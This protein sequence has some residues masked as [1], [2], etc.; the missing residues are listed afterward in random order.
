MSYSLNHQCH[1]FIRCL[2]L[3]LNR[4]LAECTYNR[5]PTEMGD[6]DSSMHPMGID[7]KKDLL[8]KIHTKNSYIKR[9]LCE[10]D[11]LRLQINQLND[12]NIHL[13]ICLKQTTNRLVKTNGDLMELKR[14]NT[15]SAEDIVVLNNKIAEISQQMCVL[16][17]EKLKYQTD[18]L[19]LGQEIHKRV[20]R[21]QEALKEKRQRQ[22]TP[23]MLKG[24]RMGSGG[25][26]GS[27]SDVSVSRRH[28]G[29]AR[30][31]QGCHSSENERLEVSVLSK[32]CGI[33][34]Y[35]FFF[36]I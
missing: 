14:Q 13:D 33:Y 22:P 5:A 21:W 31:D 29:S 3:Q 25:T 7:T 24:D 2:S 19:F 16:E 8:Y 28:A 17:K 35:F 6:G 30:N 9:L 4:E 20:D 36:F 12:K 27:D 1:S 26:S 15:I 32:V 23:T 11:S 34:I 18:I 10:N